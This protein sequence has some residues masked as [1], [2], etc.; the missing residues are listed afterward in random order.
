MATS[1]QA[2]IRFGIVPFTSN[3]ENADSGSTM[4]SV[5]Q[6]SL[7]AGK[8]PVT[9]KPRRALGDIS[10]RKRNDNGTLDGKSSVHLKTSAHKPAATS[11][12]KTNPVRKS[13]FQSV[14]EHGFTSR[15][16]APKSTVKRRVEFSIPKERSPSKNI[17]QNLSFEQIVEVHDDAISKAAATSLDDSFDVMQPAGRTWAQQIA[18]GDHDEDPCE[19]SLEGAESLLSDYREIMKK[20]HE[21]R[22]HRLNQEDEE[23][24]RY[25]ENLFSDWADDSFNE[26]KQISVFCNPPCPLSYPSLT[27][28]TK[29]LSHQESLNDLRNEC[30]LFQDWTLDLLDDL[31][32]EKLEVSLPDL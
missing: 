20:A 6:A 15:P 31:S 2:G 11:T 26:G 5:K 21:H 24:S 23:A 7:E 30:T 1:R 17:Q 16:V 13:N 10:N 4:Y 9:T 8:T 3:N 14:V 22:I 18:N 32:F 27:M 28:C 25:V 12:K 19:V 29:C